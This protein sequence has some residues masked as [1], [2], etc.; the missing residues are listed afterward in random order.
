MNEGAR[1]KVN[2]IGSV[3]LNSDGSCSIDDCLKD[4]SAE[5]FCKLTVICGIK[6]PRYLSFYCLFTVIA[7]F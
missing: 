7:H 6:Q 5:K 2:S 4:K 3:E 1:A